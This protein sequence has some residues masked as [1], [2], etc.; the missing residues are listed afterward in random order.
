MGLHVG[1]MFRRNKSHCSLCLFQTII[2]VKRVF[3]LGCSVSDLCE[4]CLSQA[5]KLGLQENALTRFVKMSAFTWID[6]EG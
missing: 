5:H 4:M 3:Y 1:F 6:K 2:I